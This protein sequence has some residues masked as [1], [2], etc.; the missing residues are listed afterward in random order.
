MKKFQKWFDFSQYPKDHPLF[1]ETNRKR[2]GKFKDE[3]NGL[4]MTR[5]IG[6]RPKL[7]SFEYLDLSGVV[8]GKN[9][10]K[11]V[12]KGMK[13]R[14]TFDEYESCLINMN[15]KIVQMN[16]I[17][18]DHHKLFTYNINKIGLSAFDDKRYILDDGITTLAH[19]HH[20]IIANSLS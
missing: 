17:R 10:A 6:L 1:D 4:C 16:S 14:L 19:G 20:R 7:Y 12:Q 3:L 2:V 9:T 13:N 15:A 11:G 8:F 18:S 5:F